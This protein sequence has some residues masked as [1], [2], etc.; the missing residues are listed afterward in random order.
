MKKNRKFLLGLG[1]DKPQDEQIRMTRG[2]NFQLLGGTKDTHGMMQETAIRFNEELK[3]K[4][5]NLETLSNHEFQ[6]IAHKLDM[7]LIPGNRPQI[8]TQN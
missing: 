7:P 8:H 5:K 1:L 2:E 4:K 6:E 3:K